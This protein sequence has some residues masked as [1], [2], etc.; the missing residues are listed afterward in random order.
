M[1]IVQTEHNTIHIDNSPQLPSFKL[2]VCNLFYHVPPSTIFIFPI[3]TAHDLEVLESG[4][5]LDLGR[6]S[7]FI[8][9]RYFK[10]TQKSSPRIQQFF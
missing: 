2:K 5:V 6:W 10:D 4:N 1:L 9:N 8:P 7:Y 3:L